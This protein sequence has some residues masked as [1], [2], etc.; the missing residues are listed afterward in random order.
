[1]LVI[2]GA[3]ITGLTAAASLKHKDGNNLIIDRDSNVGGYCQT[4]IKDDFVWDRAGHFFHFQ[5]D[6]VK[7]FFS[8]NI[9]S[10]EFTVVNKKTSIFINNAFIDFPF[11]KNIHQLDKSSYI[12][13]LTDLYLSTK[14]HDVEIKT[15]KD[16]IF[17]N[18]GEGI[19]CAFLLPYNEKLYACDLN[20][21][22]KDAM[23]RFFP[24]VEFEDVLLS[25]VTVSSSVSYNQTFSYPKSGAQTFVRVLESN[26]NKTSSYLMDTNVKKINID[27]KT[28]E[29][30]SGEVIKYDLLI[31]TMPFDKLIQCSGIKFEPSVKLSANKVLVFNIG[32]DSRVEEIKDHWIY[33]P[34]E[35]VFYRVGCYHNIFNKNKASLYVEIGASSDSQFDEK[36]LLSKVLNDLERVGLVD[37]N[38]TMIDYE[39]IV[40]DPAYVHINTESQVFKDQ[41]KSELMKKG[42]YSAGRYGDWKY[43]SIED[44]IIEA[45]SLA[46]DI[47]KKHQEYDFIDICGMYS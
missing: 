1:M 20:E 32:F 23:G 35:E 22:D 8:D 43:C 38:M 44:N 7:K 46:K 24:K 17:N 21:L 37:S 26:A 34:G 39:F 28:L 3:G 30:N 41:M 47:S 5:N 6:I 18:Y 33:Y 45:I 9:S 31:N 25:P 4:T 40:M 36:E 14:N 10:E 2:I 13:C 27:E 15:F 19:S 12:K 29:T 42:I 16:F 11:Q